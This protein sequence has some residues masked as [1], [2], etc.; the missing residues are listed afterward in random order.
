MNGNGKVVLVVDIKTIDWTAFEAFV[1]NK[2]A[3]S[4]Q[5]GILCYAK[6]YAELLDVK[7]IELQP[8]T[9]KNNIIDSLNV[10]SCFLGCS[11]EYKEALKSY[12]IK[13][14]KQNAVASFNRIFDATGNQRI[15]EEWES[16]ANLV[17]NDNEKLFL[18]FCKISGLRKQECIDSWN[19]IIRLKQQGT[20]DTYYY[21]PYQ[22]LMHFRFEKIFLR[23]KKN[24]FLTFLN[25]AT[26]DEI[27][28]S[29]RISYSNI[30]KRLAKANLRIKINLYRD[31]FPTLLMQRQISETECNLMQ[32]RV[33]GVLIQHYW[34]P[35]LA[36]LATK[37]L[38][39]FSEQPQQPQEPN[40][41][42]KNVSDKTK[43]YISFNKQ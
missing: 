33:K 37:V 39:A 40:K 3:K 27:A 25:E 16:K 4:T 38:D 23:G 28:N 1:R 9:I 34:S 36:K 24:C 15:L 22:C 17:L 2:Y 13:K 7:G 11:T 8:K 21:K 29:S 43:G 30:R 41:Y 31:M 42:V 35:E 10:L 5:A 12:G 14:Q 6:K 32:G 18:K 19:L 26:L 20:L